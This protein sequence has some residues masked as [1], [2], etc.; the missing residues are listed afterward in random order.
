MALVIPPRA[1]ARHRVSSS[2][3]CSLVGVVVAMSACATNEAPPAPRGDAGVDLGEVDL[4]GS[5]LGPLD[6]GPP[7]LGPVDSGPMGFAGTCEACTTDADCRRGSFCA[8]LAMGGRAC[9]PACV[10]DLPECPNMIAGHMNRFECVQSVTL[11]PSGADVCAPVGGVCC[12]DADQDGYGQGVGCMGPDCDDSNPL[13]NP[14]IGE[15]C[16]GY[17]DNCDHVVDGRGATDCISG[18]CREIDGMPGAFEQIR[19]A[20]CVEGACAEGELTPCGLF[21]CTR[22]S[23]GAR[24]DRCATTCAPAGT[25][26]DSFCVAAAHCDAARCEAD[27]PN[28]SACDEDTDCA[29]NHCDNGICCD[30]GRCC[31]TAADC[32]GAMSPVCTDPTNCQGVRGDAVCESHMCA[33]RSGVPDDTACDRG[34]LARDCGLYLPIYCNGAAEQTPRSCPTSCMVDGECIPAA[35][36]ELGV[37]APDR[38]QGA[39]CSRNA[40]CQDGLTCV[41]GVCCDGPCSGLCERCNLAATRG[42]CT[43]IPLGQDPDGECPGF[44]CADYYA[45]FDGM[46]RCLRRAPVSADQA[47]CNGARACL[48][49]AEVCPGQPSGTEVQIACNPTCQTPTAGTCTG[50]TPGACTNAPPGMQTCGMGACMVTVPQCNM[51][52]PVMCV[53]GMAA[54]ETCNGVDDNCNGAIDEGLPASLCPPTANVA[55]TQCNGMAGC[56]IA[57]CNAGA[58]DI[59]GAY[60][61]GCECV[62]EGNGSSCATVTSLGTVAVSGAVDTR[63]SVIPDGAESD[64]FTVRFPPNSPGQGGGTPRIRFTRN[65]GS[66]FRF[67]VSASC[68]GP[69]L[70]CGGGGVA[71]G[72]SEWSFVDDQSAPGPRQWTTRDVSWPTDVFIRVFRTDGGLS[73]AAYQLTISR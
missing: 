27:V 9:L 44:S 22:T 49:P 67:S 65:D 16:N 51:G 20:T 69:A 71:D 8:N 19:N 55:A 15:R 54:P 64:Y 31:N 43:P 70:A 39:S 28:G 25:D 33:V 50:T 30:R 68:G 24:G 66:V 52:V 48:S 2:Q 63:T 5:D 37:C 73:C 35:H 29:S 60:G 58:Y 23:S 38:P 53:A 36:C 12:V 32:G 59:N 41:D 18:I 45:G 47:V 7:D 11:V 17:D 46:N 40:D 56:S 6:L 42:F 72:I 21:T 61:D 26:D 62:N 10:R 34:T 1:A 3:I 14:G 57:A 13:V 4:G